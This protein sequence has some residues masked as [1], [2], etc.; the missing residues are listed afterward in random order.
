MQRKT[1]DDYHKLAQ[2]R[3]LRWLGT[4]VPNIQTKTAW[5]RRDKQ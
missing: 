5:E 3:G 1:P 2:E 4:E